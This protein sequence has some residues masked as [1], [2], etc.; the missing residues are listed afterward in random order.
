MLYP[1]KRREGIVRHFHSIS[2][3]R[4]ILLD[5]N[6][7]RNVSNK[8]TQPS[9]KKLLISKDERERDYIWPVISLNQQEIKAFVFLPVSTKS[10]GFCQK[11]VLV[12]NFGLRIW[13]CWHD[14]SL[15][16]VWFVCCISCEN[17]FQMGYWKRDELAHLEVLL[18]FVSA[19]CQ[20]QCW[21]CLCVFW[22]LRLSFAT[23]NRQRFFKIR[24]IWAF[25][26]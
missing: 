4:S 22:M 9:P 16:C 7:Y 21:N 8:K 25:W 5:L 1:Q 19:S 12:Q 20:T 18:V 14:F 23:K 13:L 11:C 10:L 2:F 24:R 17:K 15:L 3:F 26:F 6:Q